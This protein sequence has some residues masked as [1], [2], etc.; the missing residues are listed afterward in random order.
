M[1]IDVSRQ[2]SALIILT[3]LLLLGISVAVSFKTAPI[4]PPASLMP[5]GELITGAIGRKTAIILSALII[6][7][8]AIMLTRIGVRHMLYR[9][10]S[11]LPAAIYATMACSFYFSGNSLGIYLA[12]ALLVTGSDILASGLSRYSDFDR[13]FRGSLVIGCSLLLYAPMAVIVVAM[14]FM[15]AAISRSLREHIVAIVG[16]VLPTA[17][18]SYVYWAIGYDFLY[19]GEQLA[20]GLTMPSTI[21]PGFFDF[22]RII[23]TSLSVLLL[24]MS[25][26]TYAAMSNTMR[27][28]PYRVSMQFVIM[29]IVLTGGLA[30]PHR[31]LEMVLVLAAPYSIMAPFYFTR[32][33][34]RIS[35]GI[36]ILILLSSVGLGLTVLL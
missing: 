5:P 25:V 35:A 9:S 10:K 13:C 26:G 31:S 8:N 12:S 29:L 1:R 33:Q 27:T 28:R 32:Y 14:P 34:G 23:F 20:A 18:C 17:I 16:F 11:F 15:L 21:P 36:Y 22:L 4:L 24:F 7:Y 30:L 3:F 6:C 19:I 2:P